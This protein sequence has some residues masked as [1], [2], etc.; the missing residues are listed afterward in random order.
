MSPA[1]DDRNKY[2]G[3]HQPH[4][5]TAYFV[6]RP[7]IAVGDVV[8]FRYKGEYSPENLLRWVFVLDP[9]YEGKLHG[10]TLGLTPRDTIIH[11]VVD[12]MYETPVPADLYD[13]AIYKVAKHLDSYR[14]YFIDQMTAVR[15]MPYFITE[16]P[17]LRK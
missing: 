14:T 7:E 6:A 8:T 15:R 16:R 17:Q 13:R 1:K 3:Q 9:E 5:G 2:L 11:E 4:F 12:A 10:L